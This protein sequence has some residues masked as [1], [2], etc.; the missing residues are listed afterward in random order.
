VKIFIDYI[1]G[2]E[3]QQFIRSQGVVPLT[4]LR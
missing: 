4:D 3:G 1:L 2:K